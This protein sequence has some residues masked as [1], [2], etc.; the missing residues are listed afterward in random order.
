MY[1]AKQ[2]PSWFEGTSTKPSGRLNEEPSAHTK[3]LWT[4]QEFQ[5]K[6]DPSKRGRQ[7][8]GTGGSPVSHDQKRREELSKLTKMCLAVVISR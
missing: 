4:L 6:N 3:S 1:C 2:T 7:K 8:Q 5:A